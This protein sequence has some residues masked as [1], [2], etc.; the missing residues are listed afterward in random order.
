MVK[1]LNAKVL[2]SD[3]K[4]LGMPKIYFYYHGVYLSAQIDTAE[5]IDTDLVLSTGNMTLQIT[6]LGENLRITGQN[7]PANLITKCFKCYDI[8]NDYGDNT[9]MCIYWPV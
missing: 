5:T 7:R 6:I 2:L 8:L 3:I 1:K 4:E 9:A